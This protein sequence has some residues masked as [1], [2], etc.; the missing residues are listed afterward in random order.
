MIKWLKVQTGYKSGT[1]LTSK[2]RQKA[3]VQTS[4]II[5]GSFEGYRK[6]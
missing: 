3:G 2:T 6:K 1:T 4:V 5:L